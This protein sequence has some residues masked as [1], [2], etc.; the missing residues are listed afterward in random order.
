MKK[1]FIIIITKF[2]T[3]ILKLLGKN[4]GNLPGDLAVK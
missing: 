3:V 4:A 2:I 1:F